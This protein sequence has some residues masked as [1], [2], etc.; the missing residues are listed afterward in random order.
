MAAKNSMPERA[1]AQTEIAVFESDNEIRE[2]EHKK[3][4]PQ[5]A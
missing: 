2:R 4:R 5:T 1:I 3:G